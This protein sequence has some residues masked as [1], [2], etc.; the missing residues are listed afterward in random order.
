MH[1]KGLR[2]DFRITL[3]VPTE[4]EQVKLGRSYGSKIVTDKKWWLVRMAARDG[5]YI[6][7]NKLPGLKKNSILTGRSMEE[8]RSDVARAG[9]LLARLQRRFRQSSDQTTPDSAED[10]RDRAELARLEGVI[11]L[12]GSLG[13]EGEMVAEVV[14]ADIEA[15]FLEQMEGEGK[16]EATGVQA[17][18]AETNII[19]LTEEPSKKKRRKR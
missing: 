18:P 7:K 10:E 12:E 16:R 13:E 14:A 15:R 1:L 3:K 6:R 11:A 19:D 4:A 17:R 9:K 8:I 2:F 5:E